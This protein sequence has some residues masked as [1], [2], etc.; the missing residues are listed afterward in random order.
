MLLNTRWCGTSQKVGQPFPRFVLELCA[1]ALHWKHARHS[2]HAKAAKPLTHFAPRGQ[3][4]DFSPIKAA[5]R[6]HKAQRY[7][8]SCIL[9]L[10]M[11]LAVCLY[12]FASASASESSPARRS[13]LAPARPPQ[14]CRL[15]RATQSARLLHK[16]AAQRA[17]QGSGVVEAGARK[18][19]KGLASA[20]VH[21][22]V[23]T[24]IYA[25]VYSLVYSLVCALCRRAAM[26]SS[27]KKPMQIP[28]PLRLLRRV[29]FSL[30][31]RLQVALAAA[32]LASQPVAINPQQAM[33]LAAG[34][35]VVAQRRRL[36]V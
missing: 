14:T 30:L 34:D 13:P 9:V 1:P 12:R 11:D 21:V 8:V 15:A 28:L 19:R 33:A 35:E 24:L 25:L 4:P 22:L 23:Y 6:P 29:L 7:T 26:P 5:Q 27:G 10:H 32:L 36:V 20:L 31:R 18:C 16:L 3:S 2:V 17:A